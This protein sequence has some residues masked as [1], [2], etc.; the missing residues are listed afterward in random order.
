MDRFLHS[1]QPK[2]MSLATGI[3][4][5]IWVVRLVP[6]ERPEGTG[7]DRRGLKMSKIWWVGSWEKA[8]CFYLRSWSFVILSVF[9]LAP[10]YH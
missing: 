1:R 8:R 7:R 2:V 4:R 9:V 6:L 10:T 5:D 3:W